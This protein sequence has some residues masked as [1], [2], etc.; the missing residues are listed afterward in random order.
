MMQRSTPS[1]SAEAP[2]IGEG[3]L[4]WFEMDP[5][6]PRVPA[7]WKMGFGSA[8]A[9]DERD[10]VWILSRPH[11]LANPRST[12]P[13]LKSV[14]A[15]PVMEFDNEGNFIQGWGGES[16]P[17]YQWPSNEHGI[18]VDSR[19]F[20]WILGNADGKRNNPA[21]LP[22]DNQVLKFTREGKF[23]MAIGKSGQTGSNKTEVLRGATAMRFH[24]KTNELFV[25]DGYGNSRV[26]VYDADTGRY[27]R[28]W[29]AYGKQPLD[30]EDRPPRSAPAATPWRGVAE[31]LQQFGSPVH[32]VIISDDDLLYVCDRGNKRI[33]VFTPEGKFVAEQ[34]VGL[35]NNSGLQA[36][37]AAFSPDQRFLY[38]GGAP[39]I[40]I[41]NRKTLEVLGAFDI[42]EGAQDHPPG[43]M[44]TS[45][46]KGNLYV[47]QADVTG[48]DGKSGGTGAYKWV[49]KGYRPSTK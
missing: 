31:A 22:N 21:N 16:G 6:W 24:A 48:A 28:M 10:H 33:Q 12:E 3:G 4:P 20:V 32:E 35:N 7:K 13:D 30:E 26:I 41:L 11:T 46:H 29:G 25:T 39:V 37:G 34:F 45:D 5:A 1:S 44:I 9:V 2:H 19:G 27:K 49:F 23:V 14:A 38:V 17:G 42:A 47:V 8:V 18:S 40:Y 36:R 15:P 43:H